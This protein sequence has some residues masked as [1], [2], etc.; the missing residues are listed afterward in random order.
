[1]LREEL[2][3]S[4]S[5]IAYQRNPGMLVR[6]ATRAPQEFSLCALTEIAQLALGTTQRCVQRVLFI[7]AAM[8]AAIATLSSFIRWRPLSKVAV[9]KLQ[10]LSCLTL[11]TAAR[12]MCTLLACPTYHLSAV[13]PPLG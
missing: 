6:C 1:M 7:N 3:H 9:V 13:R 5:A 12:T 8:A 2:T 4:A 10:Q 11:V